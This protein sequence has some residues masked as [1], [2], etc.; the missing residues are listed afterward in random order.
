MKRKLPSFQS[1]IVTDSPPT[2]SLTWA[3]AAA[4]HHLQFV[5]HMST[6]TLIDGSATI[7]IISYF[8]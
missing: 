8:N 5:G 3:T 7:F 1:D 6:V 4:V 2:P